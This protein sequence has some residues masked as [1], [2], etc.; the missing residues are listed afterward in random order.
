LFD[1]DGAAHIRLSPDEVLVAVHLPPDPWP[2]AYAKARQRGSIDF[3]LAGV[4]LALLAENGIVRGLRVALTGVASRPILLEETTSLGGAALDA[5]ALERL[6]KS[7]QKAVTP[8]R[9]TAAA[10][11]YRRRVAAAFA[12]RLATG[13]YHRPTE[14]GR[15][16]AA[17]SERT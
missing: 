10:P 7:V 9:T 13:L 11:L 4:A 1:D 6:G 3:P 17:A 15:A 12:T 8:M 5:G 14:N 16:G 2:A